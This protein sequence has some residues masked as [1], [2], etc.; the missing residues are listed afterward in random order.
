MYIRVTLGFR[1]SNIITLTLSNYVNL[2]NIKF[3][4][5]SIFKKI[6]YKDISD[7]ALDFNKIKR[8]WNWINGNNEYAYFN[9]LNFG[10]MLIIRILISSVKEIS[11]INS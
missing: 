6:K 9:N 4:I 1:S 3:K 11:K 7:W 8:K 2:A 5:H 10:K